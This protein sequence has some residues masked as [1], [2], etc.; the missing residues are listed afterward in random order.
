MKKFTFNQTRKPLK[1]AII[2]RR[3]LKK[4]PLYLAYAAAFMLLSTAIVFAWF[5][6]DLPTPSKIANRQASESTKIF[7]RTGEILLY[8]TGEQKRTIVKNDQIS[9]YLKDA[10]IA[11]EDA[12]FYSHHGFDSAAVVSAVMEKVTGKTK[13]ARGGSTITQQY[14]KNAL[15][16]PNRSLT[17]KIKELILAIELEMMFSKDEILT[18]YLNEIP[19]GNST[20]GAEAA[21][22]MYY[23]KSALDLTIAESATLAAIP[24]A[25]TYYSPYGTHVKELV[26]RRNYVIDR[27]HETG[28]ISAE[29]A[30]KA[31][32]EDTTT[33]GTTLKARRDTILA[34]HFAMYVLEQVAEDYGEEKIQQEGLRIITSLDYELQK[35][36]EAAVAE[37]VGKLSRYGASNAAITAIDPKTGQILAMV[38][39]KDFFDTSIDG[40]VNVAD[41]PRQPGSSFKPITYAA[42][43]KK[44]EYSPSKILFDLQTDFGGGYIPQNYNG[45]FSGPVTTRH[46]LANSLN[47]PAVKMFAMVGMDNVIRTA[48][49]LGI[50]SLTDRDRYGLSL[51]LGVGE[52]KPVEMAG[53]FGVFANKGIKHDIKSVVKITDSRNRTLFE[54][55]PTEDVGRKALDPQ[56]AYQIS[57]ILSDNEARTP[58]FGPRSSL[59][60][61]NRP[62]AAKTGTTSDYKDAWTVGYTPS[63]SVA[64]WVGNSNGVKMK[65]GADGSIV[66]GPI[67]HR[68]I[69]SALEG[70]EP[71]Q[72]ERPE[73]IV[74]VEVEKYSNKLPSQYSREFT[75]DIFASWQVPT[76]KDD[77]H[78]PMNLCKGLNKKAP[79]DLPQVL[80]EVRVITIV[81]SE[82]PDRPNWEGPVR[83]WAQ[84]NGFYDSAPKD[85]CS[86][87][88]FS[89][90]ITITN[91]VD[92][93]SVSGEIQISADVNSPFAITSV[94]FFVDDISIGT[95]TNPPYTM[96]FNADTLSADSNHKI[97][98]RATTEFGATSTS[99]VT[100]SI[101]QDSDAPIIDNIKATPSANSVVIEWT[102]NEPATSQV[103]LDTR[104]RSKLSD[105]I[106]VSDISSSLSKAHSVT[107]TG[108]S[109]NTRYYFRVQSV[110][111]SGNSKASAEKTFKTP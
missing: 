43:F 98:A 56:I 109:P 46:A 10:T 92:S 102:T 39:S 18:M 2:T 103:F 104:E 82:F 71:E 91:P 95:V 86:A 70:I 68:F 61:P 54:Y 28:K 36:A 42:A 38:G 85:F 88:D 41:S 84:A 52:I 80:T 11:T 99:S 45:R 48:E 35:K 20:A 90:A 100:I 3:L 74:E 94:E 107:I 73:N 21:A 63:I 87:K 67:F 66:A 5:T 30:E 75:K 83:A 50:T 32:Q 55:K 14:V 105:Y 108:L 60:F 22:R 49:D 79:E 96:S 26:A 37:E 15:L 93:S 40:N 64:V 25:P 7:D 51:A 9:Q 13:R 59:F 47:I 65:T 81:Q 6:K 101:S 4:A 77:I 31:K 106:Y 58:V 12:K 8:E 44:K 1:R 76:D 57:H 69:E 17:R 24:R 23:G 111:L 89:P 62:V 72:F 97:S 29:E 53:A 34:P 78:L 27:M 19:Y 16:N 110:D 33:L